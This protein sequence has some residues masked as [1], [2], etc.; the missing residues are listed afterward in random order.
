VSIS[1]SFWSQR[2]LI[3][4]GSPVAAE[5]MATSPIPDPGSGE[6]DGTE[7][8]L[9]AEAG[10]TGERWRRRLLGTEA[11]C[12]RKREEVTERVAGGGRERRGSEAAV[13][14]AMARWGRG[15][16]LSGR[17]RSPRMPSKRTGAVM[18]AGG[19]RRG[20]RCVKTQECTSFFFY[21]ILS[22]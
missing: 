13:V 10:T 20:H 7:G 4:T 11:R 17:K 21:F 14:T 16:T 5:K 18:V 15:E 3:R 8:E 22:Q 19:W 2:S 9:A 12:R 6:E 1:T